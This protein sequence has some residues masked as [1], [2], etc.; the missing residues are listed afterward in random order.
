MITEKAYGP[1]SVVRDGNLLTATISVVATGAS[2][3]ITLGDA[4]SLISLFAKYPLKVRQILWNFEDATAKDLEVDRANL[5][6][7]LKLNT[8]LLKATAN[9]LESHQLV[10]E[11]GNIDVFSTPFQLFFTST[12][13]AGKNT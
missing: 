9:T 8:V 3:T 11:T 13:T 12:Y 5:N 2:Q 7:V 1:W 6:S 10:A 4:A